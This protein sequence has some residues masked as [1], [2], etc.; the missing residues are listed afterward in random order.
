MR[1]PNADQ[2]VADLRKLRD[3]CLSPEHPR[4]RHKARLF[5][6]ALGWTADDAEDVRLRLLDAVRSRDATFL[7]SDDYGQRYA[8]DFTPE[9]VDG[10]ITVRSLWIVRTGEGFPRLTTCYLL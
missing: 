2:A 10:V 5:K 3:Y 8:L 6:G 4:G 7:G 1:I 9:G